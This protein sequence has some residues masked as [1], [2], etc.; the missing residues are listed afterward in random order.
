MDHVLSEELCLTVVM[1]RAGPLFLQL[2]SL[3]CSFSGE[4]HGPF[5]VALLLS[6]TPLILLCTRGL[7]LYRDQYLGLWM[8]YLFLMYPCAGRKGVDAAASVSGVHISR[9]ENGGIRRADTARFSG[10]LNFR[11]FG[12]ISVHSGFHVTDQLRTCL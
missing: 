10:R 8:N 7:Y 2:Q 6:G 1:C 3:D 5:F 11:S 12:P 9:C 4:L